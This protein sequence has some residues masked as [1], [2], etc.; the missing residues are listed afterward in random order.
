MKTIFAARVRGLGA[1]AIAAVLLTACGAGQDTGEA[2]AKVVPCDFEAPSSAVTVNVL[3]YN[4]SAIDPFTNSMVKSC[5]KDSV[6]VKHDPIDF[7]GQYTK[8]PITLSAPTGTYDLVE[9]YSAMIPT[10]AAKGQLRPIDDLFDK[11]KDTYDLGGIDPLMLKGFTYDGKL[12]GLPMQ[13]NISMMAYRKDIFDK[14]GIEVPTTYAEVVAAA[15][16]IRESGEMDYPV[17]LPASDPATGYEQTMSSLGISYVDVKTDT[18]TFDSPEAEKAMQALVDLTPYMDPQASTFDQPKVQ[19]QMYNGKAAIAIMFSGRMADLLQDANSPYADDFGFAPAPGV[20]PGGP[21]GSAISVDGWT[22]PMNSK[23]DPDLLFQIMASS[24]TTEASESAMPFAYPARSD[25]ATP[26]AIPYLSAITD[27]LD[28][29][30]ALPAPYPWFTT[31][32]DTAYAPL[33]KAWK[34]DIS[35]EAALAACQKAAAVALADAS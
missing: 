24:V 14:L 12:Y 3:A 4:S 11:Y 17:A 28:N 35:V 2:R 15:K 19:Q 26:E 10:Y 1:V 31:M 33:L 6:T 30:A 13:A 9:G 27:S 5:T 20:E 7:G 22:M 18:A 32:E 21:V 23:V 16:T 29:G 8:T 34:G 25:V